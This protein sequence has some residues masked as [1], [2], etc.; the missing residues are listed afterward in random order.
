MESAGERLASW[1]GR[2]MAPRRHASELTLEGRTELSQ[3]ERG[4]GVSRKVS[5]SK[6]M[7]MGKPRIRGSQPGCILKSL[8][9]LFTGT[10]GQ[11]PPPRDT[12]VTELGW[13]PSTGIYEEL[14]RVHG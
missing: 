14:P 3:V 8:A 10:D 1:W 11:T 7:E 5:G 4:K 13:G 2:R 9:E 12:A 6:R